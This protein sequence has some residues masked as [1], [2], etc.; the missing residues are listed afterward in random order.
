M[1]ILLALVL[2]CTGA[3]LFWAA[4]DRPLEAPDWHGRFMGLSYNPSH[5]YTEHGT[6]VRA[7]LDIIRG[8]MKQL[9]NV[10]DRI[11][12]YSVS[13]G[14]DRVPYIAREF[15]IKVTLGLWLGDNLD[16]NAQEI[17]TGLRVIA[18]NR[19]VIDRVI[20]GN[21]V[22]LRNELTPKQLMSYIKEVRTAIGDSSIEVGTADV[23]ST[24]LQHPELALVSDF[25]GAHLLPYW[26]GIAA[27]RSMG[28][29]HDRVARLEKEFPGKKIVIA[30]AGWPSE[31][32]MHKGSLPSEAMES[33]FI[34]HFLATAAA[35]N[36][37]YYLIEAYD[38]P[39]KAD[40]E[41]A[42]GSFWGLFDAERGHKLTMI[43]PLSSFPEWKHYAELAAA[44][45]FVLSAIVLMLVPTLEFLGCLLVTSVTGAVVSGALVVANAASLEYIDWGTLAGAAMIVPA[46][47]FTGVLLITETIE[48]ALSLWRVKRIE[49]PRAEPIALPRVSIHVPTHNEPPAMVRQTLNALAKLDYP[50]FEVIV[51]DNNTSDAS[52]WRPIESYC[53]KLGSRFR[54]YHFDGVKGFK[55]GALN[56]AQKLTDPTASFIAVIDS[57][58]QVLP[59]WL[60]R[61][62][63]VFAD[64]KVAV[65]QA[66]QD[67]RDGEESGFKAACYE[68][69]STFFEVGMVE[70]NEHN[71]I[72]Q[73]GTM[74]VIRRD[75]LAAVG[76]WGEWC[77]TEDTELGLRLFEAGYRG[78][79]INE[80]LGR[81]LMPDT[82]S[83]Y[84]G[85]R[86]RWVY[87]AMQILKRHASALFG[88]SNLT[89][90]QRYHFVAGW[91]P[92]FADAFAVLFA[93]FALV[94]TALMTI[95]PKHFDVPLTALSATAIALFGLKLTKTLVLHRAKVGASFGRAFAAALAGVSL[96]F[97]VG[98]AVLMGLFTSNSPF[99]RTPK[100]EDQ[101]LWTRGLRMVTTEASMFA[102]LM[103]A[104]AAMFAKGIDD[105]AEIAWSVALAVSAV[106]YAAAVCVAIRSTMKPRA[107][108][109]LAPHVTPTPIEPTPTRD[110]DLAA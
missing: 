98:R 31:G 57:D 62:I 94:W 14:R 44:I 40:Q 56:I 59:S 10:T 12:T 85:Q 58:Y 103:A 76:G 89:V 43:G 96:A 24:W 5:L 60:K 27:N 65:V 84:K 87:G 91:L 33:Y 102:L 51:L 82:Y 64:P 95:A 70:R 106:P 30:E 99:V 97:V 47:L 69:Y 93:A 66:P 107:R 79:Y 9:A 109:V 15:G 4:L 25:V 78:H 71:A 26:E 81:G 61:A 74:C 39:W 34:R 28:Y 17:A 45:T 16:K 38:Q 19:D 3:A 73:H 42:V 2:V 63:P 67:Y 13:D 11:R 68:E 92:W 23:W 1:R 29:I 32:R 22:L 110:L 37:D 104:I 46:V 48:W 100:C 90:A 50:N 108:P 55:A 8:D 83:A 21:E 53:K 72:I 88:N 75:A 52:M 86:Y 77:I 6:S 105:P 41:G 35:N 101:A 18:D 36:Y 20:V 49:T 80:S 54:F 7:N